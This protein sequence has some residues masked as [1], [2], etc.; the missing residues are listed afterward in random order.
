MRRRPS[1]ST[2]EEEDEHPNPD[3]APAKAEEDK[4]EDVKK[5]QK[6]AYQQLEPK[7]KRRSS[8]AAAGAKAAW[9]QSASKKDL[10]SEKEMLELR[11]SVKGI[12]RDATVE[13]THAPRRRPLLLNP[14][15]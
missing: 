15:S 7:D 2:T 11:R 4:K 13:T 12:S 9:K 6:V 3:V 10:P 8:R 5:G 14:W 1:G